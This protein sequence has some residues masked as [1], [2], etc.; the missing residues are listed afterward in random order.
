MPSMQST[1]PM[2]PPMQSAASG[3]P[4]LPVQ[5]QPLHPSQPTQPMPSMQQPAPGP[6]PPPPPQ[7]LQPQYRQP[8]PKQGKP[9]PKGAKAGIAAGIAAAVAAVFLIGLGVF[10]LAGSSG[11]EYVDEDWGLQ[12]RGGTG[13]V[14]PG[15]GDFTELLASGSA[16]QYD[17]VL[18]WDPELG[19]EAERSVAP[20]GWIPGGQ[21]RWLMQ[22]GASPATREFYICAPDY[23]M[24]A[25]L[26]GPASYVEPDPQVD[27][28]EGQWSADYLCPI[29]YYQDAQTHAQ[30]FFQE[31]LG[32]GYAEVL[33]VSPL[34]YEAS[35]ALQS[36]VALMQQQA[37]A[38]KAQ[39]PP[40]SENWVDVSWSG[41]AAVVTLRFEADAIT[42]KAKVLAIVTAAEYTSYLTAPLI[43]QFSYREVNWQ[44]PLGVFYYVAEEGKFDECGVYADMF[45]SNLLINEQW[46][47]AV[48]QVSDEIF[49]N[50]LQNTIDQ[51]RARTEA[52]QQIGSQAVA[53]S[54]QDYYS[55]AIANRSESQHKAMD[56]WTNVIAGREYFEGADGAPVL[57]D[58]SYSHTYSNG[59]G[60]FV[61]SND[62][63]DPPSGWGEV[64]GSAM[65]TD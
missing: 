2:Q 58:S 21:V 16:I 48:R 46:A 62:S 28:Y 45:F 35:Q 4:R 18:C 14:G 30:S 32:L 61:Q 59:S 10:A 23:S 52:L 44:T 36:Y 31:Y 39:M 5:Q 1:Q 51:I 54:S 65:W 25:G 15:T 53:Q 43:G 38:V 22:S 42:Y 8:A 12:G 29:R 37:D 26:V 19:C 41:D 17:R 7:P 3:P 64:S 6:Q 60:S 49:A 55:S 13:E 11:D 47:G 50:H 34:D 40:S 24:Q 33:D 9:L 63:F 56:G 20:A 27:F 57:L